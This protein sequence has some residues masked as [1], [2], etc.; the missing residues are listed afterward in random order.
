MISDTVTVPT[1]LRIPTLADVHRRRSEL[2]QYAAQHQGSQQAEQ[3]A[4][5]PQDEPEETTPTA[6]PPGITPWPTLANA[7]YHGLAGLAVRTIAPHTEADPAAIL[8]QFLAAFG[9]MVGPGPHCVVESTRHNLNLFVVLVGES[10]KAR[11]GTSWRHICRLF[12]EVDDLWVAHRVTSARLT[13]DGLIYTLRDQDPPTDRRL[14]VLSEEFA[15]VLHVLAREKGYLSPLLRC[16]WDSG[17]LRTLDRHRSLQATGAHVSLI[18]HI[19]QYELAQ[20]LHRT[21][22]HNGFANRCLWTAVRRSQCLPEG[23]SLRPEDLAGVARQLRR[24]LNWVGN[25]IERSPF[26]RD[27]AAR[28]LWNDRYFVLSHPR[29][30]LFGAATSRAEAQVLRL[31]AIY[32]ALDCSPIV[33]TQHLEAALAVWDYCSASA[34]L[35]FVPAAI[36]PIV[37]RIREALDASPDGLTRDQIRSLFQHHVRSERIDAALE[38][39]TTLGTITSQKSRGRGRPSTLWSATEAPETEPE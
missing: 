28:Q 39:L 9:N 33:T 3:P 23:G 5:L 10:S 27:A 21:E 32:A 11:K 30:A 26:A 8:L 35:I 2:L 19:T 18:G 38:Q 20:H 25:E 31:S 34:A 16:A 15:G 7:A 13:A 36:D 22:A 4:D 1:S 14:L 24:T 37:E 29:A 17:N 6:P 12:S